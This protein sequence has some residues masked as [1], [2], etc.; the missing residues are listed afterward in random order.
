MT[1]QLEVF[2]GALTILGEPPLTTPN[3]KSEAGRLLRDRWKPAVD[4]VF[5]QGDWNFAELRAVLSRVSPA[6]AFGY[7]YYYGLPGDLASITF[8]SQSGMEGDEYLDWSEEGG[9]IATNATTLYIKYI[10]Y[11][12]KDRLGAWTQS[13]ADYVA[14]DLAV[15]VAPKLNSS[16]LGEAM[17]IREDARKSA[18]N[19]D[20]RRTAVKRPRPGRW[21]TAARWGGR[22]SSEQGR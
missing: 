11:S 22:R 16:A 21:A 10:S 6:P 15:R 5:E 3:V 4:H 13:F 7:E 19:V 9:K 2:N 20:V 14:A 8:V 1:T 18:L 12:F 17:K